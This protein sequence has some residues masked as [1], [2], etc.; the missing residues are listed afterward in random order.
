MEGALLAAQS[1]LTQYDDEDYYIRALFESVERAW[2]EQGHA[3]RLLFS[4][5]GL[6][7][8]YLDSGD[9]YFCQCH[10]TAR[11]VAQGLDLDAEDWA[12][13]FQ[14]RV[15]REEWLRP[16]TDELLTAWG[17]EG[18]ESVQVICP[19]FAADCLET[20]EEID[21]QNRAFFTAAG[22]GRFNYIPALNDDPP[23][24][25]ALAE[26]V[27]AKLGDWLKALGNGAP[28]GLATKARAAKLGAHC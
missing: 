4:F 7:R 18:L 17:Q 26:L 23:H 28:D 13:S 6:P 24:I 5:H 25:H 27:E 10:K 2:G 20:I 16:Y 9:P 22:G 12:V 3:R 21:L 14:S 19:G 1:A 11:L 8:R 15:G